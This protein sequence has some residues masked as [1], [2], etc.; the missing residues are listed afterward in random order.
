MRLIKYSFLA[1][2]LVTFTSCLK[3]KNDLG[4]LANDPG[5]VLASIS[6]SQYINTDLQNIGFHF[7]HNSFANFSYTTPNEPVKFF[8]IKVTQT[9][10][11]KMSGDMKIRFKTSPYAGQGFPGAI[12]YDAV[13]AGAIVVPADSTITIPANAASVFEYPVYFTINKALL[14]PT[15][16]YGIEFELVSANQGKVNTSDNH[17]AVVFN[18]LTNAN[19]DALPSSRI[20][21][22][23][24]ATTNIQD[25]ARAFGITNNTRPYIL[26]EGRYDPW[27]LGAQ[28]SAFQANHIFAT[29]LQIY[30]LGSTTA[31]SMYA[32]NL[33][34][35]AQTQLVQVVYRIDAT[36]KVVDVLNRATLTSLNPVFDNSVSNSFVYTDND[37]RELNV[38][39]TIRLTVGGLNRPFTITE[40]YTYDPMQVYFNE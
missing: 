8:T 9:R 23:Y 25:S 35:G 40:R 31:F 12:V 15:K 27:W 34:T 24:V 32:L 39:Y 30:G 28:G 5:T 37:T 4:G 10:D 1:A 7:S 2:L 3:S 11:T 33:A 14:D 13:P 21:G 29:D 6:E 20:N 16:L 18:G 36:G 38:K 26:S 22:R 17:I 19:G